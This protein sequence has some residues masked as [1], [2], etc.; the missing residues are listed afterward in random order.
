MAVTSWTS[1]GMAWDTLQDK[2]LYPYI[3]ALR[4]ALIERCTVS[5]VAVPAAL[6]NPVVTGDI[7]VYDSDWG[8]QFEDTITAL[9]PY[10]VNHTDNGGNWHDVLIVSAA[11]AAN[12][13]P[14]WTEANI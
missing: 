1:E 4:Q 14:K 9:I 8:K 12:V 13:P 11:A 10:F 2:Q 7:S 6:Q 5:G 3:E